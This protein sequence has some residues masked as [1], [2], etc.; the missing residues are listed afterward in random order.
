MIIYTLSAVAGAGKTRVATTYAVDKAASANHKTLIAGPTRAWAKQVEFDVTAML[1]ARNRQDIRVTRIDGDTTSGV[2]QAIMRHFD[3]ACR[4]DRRDKG[5]ILFT[6]HSG[7]M[8]CPHFSHAER[9]DQIFDEIPSPTVNWRKNIPDH[10][11][12]ITDLCELQ[13]S[14]G[15]YADVVIQKG[16]QA[17]VERIVQNERRDEVRAML[18][19]ILAAL[20]SPHWQVQAQAENWHRTLNGDVEPYPLSEQ[21]PAKYPLWLFAQLL[22]S[23]V[24]RGF[25]STTIMGAAFDESILCK[26]WTT[27]GVDF[28]PHPRLVRRL[29]ETDDRLPDWKDRTIHHPNGNRLRVSYLMDGEWSRSKG[30]KAVSDTDPTPWRVKLMQQAEIE[31]NGQDYLYLTNKS[32]EAEAREYMPNGSALPHSPH[33]LNE[34]QGYHNVVIPAACRPNPEHVRFCANQSIS[35]EELITAMHRQIVYQAVCRSSIRDLTSDQPV[36]FLVPD[37]ETAKWLANWWPGCQVGQAGWFGQ[38]WHGNRKHADK[39]TAHRVAELRQ[40]RAELAEAVSAEALAEVIAKMEG[41]SCN[42]SSKEMSLEDPLHKFP[43]NSDLVWLGNAFADKYDSDIDQFRPDPAPKADVVAAIR[44]L[45]GQ[46]IPD[47]ERQVLL[48]PALFVDRPDPDQPDKPRRRGRHNVVFVGNMVM[49]DVDGGELDGQGEFLPTTGL[50]PYTTWPIL[51]PDIEMIIHPTHSAQNEYKYHVILFTDRV[52]TP[53]QYQHIA[54]RIKWLVEQSGFAAK[55]GAKKPYHGIDRSKLAPE[56]MMY[57]PSRPQYMKPYFI[58]R[59]GKPINVVKWCGVGIKVPDLPPEP[60][61]EP[62]PERHQSA[63]KQEKIAEQIADYLAIPAGTGQRHAAFGQ[64][65]FRL[66]G[67]A[68][69]DFDL[70]RYLNDADTDG[71]QAREGQIDSLVRNSRKVAP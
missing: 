42:R 4:P 33:G 10:H 69:D 41:N 51:F 50:L 2:G 14:D 43:T 46:D 6:T 20:A 25:N 52:M 24:D 8:Q 21:E 39:S 18:R 70:R 65:A 68:L 55:P 71:H 32:D 35:Q 5:E 34:Y 29:N 64:L 59:Q 63:T 38:K 13:D 54:K 1:A 40:K 9:W 22:P 56:N 49:I 36:H 11:A 48:S 26:A 16:M 47:K 58:H 66:R 53:L 31:F 27:M 12:L 62:V 45:A 67:L 61:P 7:Y 17:A 28:R 44:N 19:P 3:E 57:L 15:S 30:N 37:E 23:M 60:E